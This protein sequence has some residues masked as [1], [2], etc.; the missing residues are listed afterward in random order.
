MVA[1]LPSPPYVPEP[2]ISEIEADQQ[3]AS[4]RFALKALVAKADHRFRSGDHRGA[5]AY[6]N[7]AVKRASAVPGDVRAAQDMHRAK[8]MVEWLAGQ[9]RHHILSS[10]ED[11]GLPDSN[12]PDRFRTAVQILLGD[13]QRDLVTERFPQIPRRFFYPGL[14]YVDFVDPAIFPWREAVEGQFD[15]MREEA[16]R[17]LTAAED[18]E[19]YLTQASGRPQGDVHA[20]VDDPKWSTLYLWSNGQPVESNVAR[21]PAIFKTIMDNVPLCHIGSSVPAVLL[22]LLKPGAHIPP[23]SGM[24]NIRYICHLP[25]IVPPKCRLR[26]GERVTEWHEGRLL[27]FDDTVEHEAHN[28]STMDRLVLIFD[29]WNPSLTE[30]EKKLVR[31]LIE[32]VESYR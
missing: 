31:A 32:T 27:A 4:E 22:S 7:F 15:V 24:M 9:F 6:Y 11:Q 21:C 20:L 10:L 17:L 28:G 26:V 25:L 29:V 16:A 3:L 23:H 2:S 1:E 13:R 12:W 18:F 30:E 5:A 19:P 8:T 14:P